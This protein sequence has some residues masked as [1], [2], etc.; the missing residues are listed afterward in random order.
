MVILLILIIALALSPAILVLLPIYKK[1]WI[2]IILCIVSTIVAILMLSA[3]VKYSDYEDLLDI[4]M[5]RNYDYV[6]CFTNAQDDIE[7]MDCVIDNAKEL[8]W[9]YWE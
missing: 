1:L 3:Y 2:R 8:K 4:V 6:Q 7:F 5:Q 9:I